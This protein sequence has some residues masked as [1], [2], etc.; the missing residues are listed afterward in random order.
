MR[1]IVLQEVYAGL[2]F[3]ISYDISKSYIWY[4]VCIGP[5]I[6]HPGISYF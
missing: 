6:A 4:M 3:Y 2:Y 5:P 1:Y